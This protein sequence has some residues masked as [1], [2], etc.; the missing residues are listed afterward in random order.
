LGILFLILYNI[1]SQKITTKITTEGY[2]VDL[3]IDSAN[4]HPINIYRNNKLIKTIAKSGNYLLE[5]LPPGK[6]QYHIKTNNKN[7]LGITKKLSNIKSFEIFKITDKDLNKY[8]NLPEF[9]FSTQNYNVYIST[10]NINK[11]DT[12][13]VYRDK[14]LKLEFSEYNLPL[15]APSMLIEQIEPGNYIYEVEYN[16]L[17]FKNLS[18]LLKQKYSIQVE[19]IKPKIESL[20]IS[21]L[22]KGYSLNSTAIIKDTNKCEAKLFLYPPENFNQNN[23]TLLKEYSFNVVEKLDKNYFSKHSKNWKW[24]EILFPTKT[25]I[26]TSH[27]QL[28]LQFKC[29][30]YYNS[31]TTEQIYTVQIMCKGKLVGQ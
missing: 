3:N 26:D 20:Y 5:Y 13:K 27:Y 10:E 19:S 21:P 31:T 15:K 24:E 18:G 30:D 1:Y 25:D 9:S 29:F 17:K 16:N 11:D 12:I 14:D 23:K 4:N 22:S 7:L 8:F 2:R 28:E 6:Y